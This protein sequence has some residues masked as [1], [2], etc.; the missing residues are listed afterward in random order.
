MVWV[1]RFLIFVLVVFS[2]SETVH[3]E[4]RVALV[5]GNSGY[6][7]VSK[8][9]NPYN[10]AKG[11]A[12]KLEDLN[13]D[14]VEGLDL[15]LQKLRIKIN[16]FVS[17]LDQAD[18]ALFFYAG[19]GLQVHGE[20]YI[21]PTDAQL[22]SQLDLEFEAVPI[23][24]I[25]RTME[26]TSKTNLVFLDAC[27]DNPLAEN[28]ARS[29]GT[30]STAVGRGLAKTSSGIGTLIS[31]ATQPGNVALDGQ[32]K[33]SPFTKAL[34]KHLGT[35]GQDISR[36]LIAVRRDV[37]A[38][39]NGKQVPWENSSLTGEIILRPKVPE[40][41]AVVEKA[42]PPAV[43]P[44]IELSYWDTI[45]NSDNALYF[46]NYLKRFPKGQFTDIAIV[47]VE[48]LK[49]KAAAKKKQPVQP[50]LSAEIAFWQSIQK[51]KNP[52][53]F[54]SYIA[55][56]PAGVYSEL[57]EIRIE[58]L[59]AE[60]AA[61][62]EK[63]Q[64]QSVAPENIKERLHSE[65]SQLAGNTS[66]RPVKDGEPVQPSP[67]KEELARSVQTELIRLGCPVGKADGLWGRKSKAAL[68]QAKEYRSL[69]LASLEPSTALINQLKDLAERAC[70]IQCASGKKLVGS[71]CVTV[72]KERK[73]N[74]GSKPNNRASSNRKTASNC[75]SAITAAHQL[76]GLGSAR[77][78]NSIK[79]THACG[80]SVICTRM[81]KGDTWNCRWQ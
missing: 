25:L 35:P 47:R 43:D 2:Y 42:K 39:T 62:L 46:E 58:A 37:L 54:S 9:N 40:K 71:K 63:K 6:Q 72:A 4:R 21:L 75:P 18:I 32:G 73:T 64:K 55:R 76:W 77:S 26:Q 44:K 8:L 22:N 53:S 45:K 14:V 19:H 1:F 5:I 17:K 33:N 34:L 66:A 70:P 11:M 12:E 78:Q 59:L 38:A 81:R 36:D 51:S 80:R 28:L 49:N 13:F 31:F 3:A 50:D 74:T 67:S 27:R 10:D 60:R 15:N 65:A 68:E 30:R 41:P 29:M 61:E 20:N 52:K 48:E 16:E 79:G 69:E 24:L 23:N 7:H 57:A 56:Y